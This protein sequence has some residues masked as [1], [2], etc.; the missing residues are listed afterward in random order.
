MIRMIVGVSETFSSA[1]YI[2]DHWKCGKVHGHNFKVEVEVEG[3]VKDG[4]VVDFFDLKKILREI[5]SRYD[6]ELLNKYFENPTSENICIDI[7]NELRRR[8]LNV[9]RVRV[10][11]NTDKWA[12][13]RV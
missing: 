1:H 5:L 2:P 7:F 6:H 11:E 3:E 12:E 9:V 8:G 10:Y 4:M 13:I